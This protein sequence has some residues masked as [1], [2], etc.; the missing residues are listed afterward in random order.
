MNSYESV[1]DNFLNAKR[2][3][4]EILSACEMID[5]ESLDC[6]TKTYNLQ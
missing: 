1:L 5:K 2:N 4:G 6:V 3:L